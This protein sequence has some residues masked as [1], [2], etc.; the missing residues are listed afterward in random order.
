MKNVRS[1]T[2]ELDF[3]AKEIERETAH[4]FFMREHGGSDP[5]WPDGGNMNLTRNHI[6]YAKVRIREICEKT[7]LP[8]PKQ[9]A[10]ETPPEVSNDYVAR[11]E[12]IRLHAK[13]SL[14]QYQNDADYRYLKD[15]RDLLSD[16]VGAVC[17]KVC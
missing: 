9:Y 8:Y 3:L 10:M 13:F 16:V 15:K 6:L 2:E 5:F 14:V 1:D 7:G 17:N 4:W 11:K 12:D